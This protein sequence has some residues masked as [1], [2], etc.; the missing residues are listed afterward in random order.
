MLRGRINLR[1]RLQ[2]WLFYIFIVVLFFLIIT[3]F[4]FFRPR[5]RDGHRD[6]DTSPSYCCY[7]GSKRAKYSQLF[8]L[9]SNKVLGNS[10]RETRKK[11]KLPSNNVISHGRSNDGPQFSENAPIANRI[12]QNSFDCVAKNGNVYLFLF[13]FSS[14]L[15]CFFFFQNVLFMN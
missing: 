6:D 5:R 14:T 10:R 8:S 2:D 12:Q 15:K 7:V 1:E 9:H 3:N 11:K 13:F 4:L